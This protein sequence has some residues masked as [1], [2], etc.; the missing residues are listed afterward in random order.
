MVCLP[1]L[2]GMEGMAHAQEDRMIETTMRDTHVA[3]VTLAVSWQNY[4]A[5]EQLTSAILGFFA[6][7]ACV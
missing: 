3:L 2:L 4:P 7:A 5:L 6:P 1:L